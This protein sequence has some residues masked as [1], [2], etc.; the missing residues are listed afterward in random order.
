MGS[1]QDVSK[2]AQDRSR[3]PLV[4]A[5]RDGGEVVLEDDAMR[6]L[7]QRVRGPLLVPG[8]EGFEAATRLWNGMVQKKPALVIQPTG[9]ADVVAAVEFARDHGLLF[10]VRGGGHNIA[11][12]AI[13]DGGLTLDMSRL[14]GVSVDPVARIAR[15]Q[16]GCVLGDVTH[17]TQLHGLAVPLGF[18][19]DTGVAGL[20]L[21]GGIGLLS[22]R[23]GYTV[24][25]L[26]EVEI[27]TADGRVRR[28]SRDEHEDLFWALRGAGANMGVV[29][30]FT[31][32]L[33]PVGPQVFGG[34]LAWPFEQAEEVL[35]AYRALTSQAPRELTVF[36]L[37][38]RAP[39]APFIAPEWQ[40]RRV[41]AMAVCYTGELSR[42]SQVLA[43][44][45][46]L[47]KPAVSLVAEQPFEALQSFLDATEPWGMHYYWKTEYLASL[48][49]A[50]LSTLRE[51]FAGCPIPGAEL[52]F[53]HIGGA[54]NDRPP[55][56]GVVGNRDAQFALG[57]TGMW[58]PGEPKAAE[59]RQWVRDAWLR[60][61]PFSTGGNYI[62]FQTADEGA[63]R[64]EATYG[65]N[66][67]RLL[68]IKAEYDPE[69]LFRS[70]RNV[71]REQGSLH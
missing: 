43:P 69:N 68:A 28:A 58:E 52:G 9:A 66:Y 46:R 7:R 25:N 45:E 32:Q 55:A 59:Y 37:L 15:V 50:L 67:Q 29:T 71:R 65:V 44:L 3:A 54:L 47:G 63:E 18:I 30:S 14:R 12:T 8:D 60:L 33:H 31:F 27:V 17:E 39:P 6:L 48:D 57:I 41:C 56:D 13:A 62:N 2:H 22:R 61:R 36:L 10:S 51:T 64:I 23:F 70:N 26:L 42:T 16:A 24:D 11:G 1:T 53:L 20:T 38:L 49:D 4:V 19:S 34:L 40:G 21:G 35:E 5:G